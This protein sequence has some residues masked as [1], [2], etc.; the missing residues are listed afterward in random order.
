MENIHLLDLCC[1]CFYYESRVLVARE[2]EIRSLLDVIM[3]P[4]PPPPPSLPLFQPLCSKVP[5][6]V[7]EEKGLPST[8][9]VWQ[10]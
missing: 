10:L 6:T 8:R 5:T 4:Q 3:S 7:P 1:T 2:G 9:L